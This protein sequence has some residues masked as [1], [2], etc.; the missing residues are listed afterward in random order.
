MT[1]ATSAMSKSKK[2]LV[3][4]QQANKYLSSFYNRSNKERGQ[5][6]S[7]LAWCM[8]GVPPE[9]L[10]AFDV[11][12]EFPEN[13]GAHCASTLVATS[14]IEIA[15]SEGYC[16]D[17]CSYLTNSMGYVKRYKD[18]GAVPP[19]SPLKQGMG[20][21]TMMMGSGYMCDPR[22]KWFQTMNTRYFN[23]PVFNSDPISPPFDVDIDD[24]RIAEHYT[25][26]LRQDL[27]AQVAFLEENT[28]KKLD[29]E[30][31]L[32]RMANSQKALS[33]WHKIMAL[34]KTRPCPMAAEDYFTAIIPQLFMLGAEEPVRF[35]E[36]IL[37]EVTMRVEKGIGVIPNEKYR[38][39]WA[40]GS[41]P[42][43]FNL[44]FFNY[45]GTLGAVVVVGEGGYYAGEPMQIDLNPADPLESL[46]QRTWRRA[47]NLH[48]GKT[49]VAPECANP[50]IFGIAGIDLFLKWA[51][52][53]Q[54]DGALMHKTRSCRAASV[55]QI[56]T[57]NLL[58]DAG[59]NTL[60]F[61]SDMADPR[62]W[63]DERIKMQVEAFLEGLEL[64]AA[65]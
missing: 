55:G 16:S 18:L 65:S 56:H 5:G 51:K 27:H 58:E 1:L 20:E 43:W 31:F 48:R 21:P 30:K 12:M 57:K 33:L 34:R 26:Q 62:Q 25:L 45:L 44:G 29:P 39:M 42:P 17:L 7:G 64:T 22:L 46:V 37:E 11:D 13:F 4:I 2:S 10:G 47:C 41:I 23:V 8:A 15:E 60:I 36:A 3:A 50:A 28:G 6:S 40:A 53:Y 9:L 54:V 32:Q 49:V 63:S 14:F 61:E 35:Y 38:L 24:P 19:E 52:E 59:I